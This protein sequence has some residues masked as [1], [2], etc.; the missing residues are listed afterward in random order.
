MVSSLGGT[1]DFS[2][3]AGLHTQVDA[4]RAQWA[5]MP[6]YGPPE[7]ED[8]ADANQAVAEQII[9][10]LA[11][12]LGVSMA[13]ATAI[14]LRE[15]DKPLLHAEAAD[16]MGPSIGDYV[17]QQ[18]G[19][20]VPLTMDNIL[21]AIRNGGVLTP[22]QVGMSGQIAMIDPTHMGDADLASYLALVVAQQHYFR[23]AWSGEA[24]AQTAFDARQREMDLAYERMAFETEHF[25]IDHLGAGPSI[26]TLHTLL[27]ILGMVPVVG[28]PADGLN[29]GIYIIEGD[30]VNA[31]LSGAALI[32]VGGQAVTGTRLGAKAFDAMKAIDG[33]VEASYKY[34]DGKLV[35]VIRHTD[36]STSTIV[37]LADGT[38]VYGARTAD[39][40]SDLAARTPQKLPRYN[41]PKPTYHVNPAHVP[42]LGLKPG[43]TP[44]PNDA[45]SV[46]VNAVPNDPV[47]PTAWFGRNADGQIYRFSPGNDGTM[48]FSGIDG[49]GDGVRNLTRYAIDR[50]NGR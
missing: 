13:E 28:E 26:E 37:E 49:V 46:Y 45:H 36:G 8:G 2:G 15:I 33:A 47:N 14:F 21:A 18:L 19:Q 16:V 42:G 1:D 41:G 34:A 12:A 30:W 22:T 6:T 44:L 50:L 43:K 10:E 48:H 23:L 5:W 32:P 11:E 38:A 20:D 4:T 7:P 27:D 17:R 31:G 35:H 40:A 3:D 39:E 9:A 25:G 29:A 24:D